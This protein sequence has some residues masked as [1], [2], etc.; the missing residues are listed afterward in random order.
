M[1]AIGRPLSVF[2]SLAPF[3]RITL[4]SKLWVSWVGLRGAVPIIF[5]TYP[6]VENVQGAGQIFNIVFFVTLL[7]LL[8][9]GTTVISSARRLDLIDTDATHD[10]DFGVELAD[11]LPTSL[12]TIEL[13]EKDLT[14][15]NTLRD[16]SLP[17]GS[18]VMMV[19]RDRRYMVPNGTLKLVPGDRLL[20]IQED[21][22]PDSKHA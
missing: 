5:A 21:I 8:V 16:M 18:L 15:G 20:V 13:S 6:V 12:H 14:K 4:R 10:D 7:S 22:T 17:K 19:K 1:I 9:Q 11:E 3:R 2:I